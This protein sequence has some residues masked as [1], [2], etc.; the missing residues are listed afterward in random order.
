MHVVVERQYWVVQGFS[1]YVE[2]RFFK[3][4][5]TGSVLGDSNPAPLA[6]GPG[7]F[8]LSKSRLFGRERCMVKS[9]RCELTTAVCQSQPYFFFSKMEM[10]ILAAI[11]LGCY[12]NSI[13]KCV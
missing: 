9:S 5:T 7:V 10:R 4:Q 2:P 12:R 8:I 3:V 6:W 1:Y 13:T 11:S